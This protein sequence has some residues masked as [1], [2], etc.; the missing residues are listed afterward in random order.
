[1]A[2]RKLGKIAT[3]LGVSIVVELLEELRHLIETKVCSRADCLAK[4]HWNEQ[5]YAEEWQRR[6]NLESHTKLDV[7]EA[8]MGYRIHCTMLSELPDAVA[9]AQ[10]R[11][12]RH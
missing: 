11:E 3:A 10:L 5:Q 1:M 12:M 2:S 4:P 9:A 7:A 6:F 8:K